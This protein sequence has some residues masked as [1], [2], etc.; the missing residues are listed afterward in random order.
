MI[1]VNICSVEMESFNVK[2]KHNE[3][4][5]VE[6]RHETITWWMHLSAVSKRKRD[7]YFPRTNPR[8][9]QRW[10]WNAGSGR[11]D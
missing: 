10:Q 9:G 1:K 8:K 2:I 7:K 4:M 11:L 3:R 5:N 6:L